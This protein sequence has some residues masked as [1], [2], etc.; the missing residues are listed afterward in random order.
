MTGTETLED[1]CEDVSNEANTVSRRSKFVFTKETKMVLLQSV[2]QHDAHRAPHGKKDEYFCKVRD[3]VISNLPN[4]LWTRMQQPSMKTVRD[5]LRSM[6]SERSETNRRN[7]NSSGIDE[8]ISSADQLMDDFLLEV[9]EY[10]EARQRNRD[11]ATAVEDGL[12]SAGE[13]IQRNALQRRL[14][15]GDEGTGSNRSTPKKRRCMDDMSG[16]EETMERAMENKCKAVEEE[17]ELRK[18]ELKLQRERWEEDKLDRQLQ[19]EQSKQ[20][21]ELLLSLCSQKK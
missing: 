5:K 17:L 1:D 3:T 14:S 12:V 13:Q 4:S 18:E 16:W 11:E 2:R 8:E 20:Q 21:M 7:L 6:L 19:R 10:N 9:K 15:V